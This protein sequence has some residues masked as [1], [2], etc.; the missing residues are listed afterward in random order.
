MIAAPEL[1]R[2]LERERSHTDQVRRNLSVTARWEE[3]VRRRE[4]V[5]NDK[6]G[7]RA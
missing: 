4:G 2:G 1:P 7:P 3:A 5:M 6:S